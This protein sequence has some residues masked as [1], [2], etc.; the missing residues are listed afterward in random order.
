MTI[1]KPQQRADVAEIITQASADGTALAI[2]GAGSKLGLG[3]HA[4][5]AD[6]L[7]MSGFAGGLDYQPS[8]LVLSAGAG[9]P[10][11]QIEALLAENRQMLAFEPPDWSGLLGAGGSG[12]LGGVIATNIA[13][14]RRVKSGAPRDHFLGFHGVN[15]RGDMFKAGGR[16]VKNVTG[17]DL[18]KIQAGAFGTLAVLTDITLKVV[19]APETSVTLVLRG[20]DEQAAFASMTRALNSP[21]EVSGAA[22]L[23]AAA[24]ARAGGFGGDAT[25]VTLLRLEGHG[26]SVA[27]RAGALASMLA[28]G[29]VLPEAASLA[30]WREIAC[31][32]PLLQRTDSL[33]WKL[34]PQPSRAASVLA[35]VQA[36]L[37]VTSCFMDWGG[38]L[39]WIELDPA[40]PDAGAGV[41]REALARAG[42]HAMLVRASEALRAQVPVFAPLE[43]GLA[44]LTARIKAAYDPADVL[45]CGRMYPPV[46]S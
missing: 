8:E 21:H 23:P 2:V 6:Q 33:V 5:C 18:A 41:M 30:L 29:D 40:V 37:P 39:L 26:P 4:P 34:N 35:E 25:S 42:G 1:H 19:P 46:V 7:D 43:A 36:R 44:R 9:T 32:Q 24:A 16:V 17:Y 38:G 3:R 22:F 12:T 10:L 15:G 13:G 45:N 27:F 11:A 14:P 31:V 28:G 20:E